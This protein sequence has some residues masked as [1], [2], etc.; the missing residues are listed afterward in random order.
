MTP[1]EMARSTKVFLVYQKSNTVLATMLD[2]YSGRRL[3]VLAA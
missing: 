3:M 2:R 1:M